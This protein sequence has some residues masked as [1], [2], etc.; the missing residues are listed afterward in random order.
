MRLRG[1]RPFEKKLHYAERQPFGVILAPDIAIRIAV[2]QS[3][4]GPRHRQC[5]R[6][7]RWVAYADGN[8]NLAH[9]RITL[10]VK[11]D[12]RRFYPL[13]VFN[14]FRRGA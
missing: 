9:Q 13:L 6:H 14:C 7:A 2:R 12:E 3:Q 1:G 8:L 5:S 10:V 11:R 4:R